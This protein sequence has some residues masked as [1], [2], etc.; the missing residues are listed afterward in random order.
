MPDHKLTMKKT[1]QYWLSKASYTMKATYLQ[2]IGLLISGTVGFGQAPSQE[3]YFGIRGGYLRASTDLTYS[4]YNLQLDGLAPRNSFYG[5]V[6]YHHTV[7]HQIAYRVELNY[8]QKGL[9]YKDQN[10]D[11]SSRNKFHYV[12]LTPL[13]GITPLRGLSFFIGPEINVNVR[14]VSAEP[15]ARIR[16]IE[17]GISG[18]VSYR[19]KWIGVEAGYFKAFNDYMVLDLITAQSSFKNHSW[20]AGLFFTPVTFRTRPLY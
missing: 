16:S 12:G 18:R 15:N 19:Y 7:A 13:I 20:Q 2:I 9:E 11:V 5:G 8:Q 4:P 3:S 1:I 14:K 17:T 6:F 10:G